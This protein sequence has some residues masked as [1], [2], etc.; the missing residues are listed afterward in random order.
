MRPSVPARVGI[1]Q[2][3]FPDENLKLNNSVKSGLGKFELVLEDGLEIVN[4]VEIF[5]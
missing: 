3:I 5:H 1:T 2:K 4:I